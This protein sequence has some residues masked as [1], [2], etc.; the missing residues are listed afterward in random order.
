MNILY[1]TYFLNGLLMIAMPI[2]LAV[3]LR[4]KF[5]LGWRL[6]WIGAA[7]FILSQ[8]GHIPFN[9][10]V[11]QVL[12]RT[13]MV[14]WSS[15]AQTIFNAVFAGLSA[16]IFEE[17]CRYGMYRWWARDARSW[18]KG[19][20]AGA[21]HGG[22][23]AMLLGLLVFYGFAQLAILSNADPAQLT[24]LVGAEKMEYVRSQI[25]A[26]WSYPWYATLLGAVERLFALVLHLSL[27]VIV[28]QVF[29]RRNI[30]WLF[31]AIGYHALVDGSAVFARP[32]LSVYGLEAVVGVFAVLSLAIIFLLCQPEPVTEPEPAPVSP[33]PA[34]V[35]K[36]IEE[37]D[38]NLEKT[39]YQ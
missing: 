11:G 1:V 5:G 39:R 17:V 13:G 26:A 34:P 25:A 4:R 14:Y 21:G 30:G 31:V 35:V 15:T 33:I 19:L 12:N 22:V 3:F 6:F 27:S 20:M 24:R 2:G 28:L 32:Y 10:G 38:E 23:E 9:W 29:T 18:G 37:T 7:T 8:V 16:G 36:P